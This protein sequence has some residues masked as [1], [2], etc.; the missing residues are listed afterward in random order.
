MELIEQQNIY[1]C[2]CNNTDDLCT[3]KHLCVNEHRK[4]PLRSNGSGRIEDVGKI[5]SLEEIN[6]MMIEKGAMVAMVVDREYCKHK[7]SLIYDNIHG[8]DIKNVKN[9]LSTHAP[10]MTSPMVDYCGERISDYSNILLL[11]KNNLN[12]IKSLAELFGLVAH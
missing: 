8:F 6:S 1:V 4:Y 7:I 3:I 2:K 5:I 11:T 12:Y 10:D 9:S